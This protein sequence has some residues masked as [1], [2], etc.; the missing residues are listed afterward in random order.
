MEQEFAMGAEGVSDAREQRMNRCADSLL[1]G[2]AESRV[3][4]Q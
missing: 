2:V 1:G 3:G 4:V